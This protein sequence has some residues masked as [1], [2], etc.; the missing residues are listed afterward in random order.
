MTSHDTPADRPRRGDV[1]PSLNGL[2]RSGGKVV[3]VYAEGERSAKSTQVDAA[4]RRARS[5]DYGRLMEHAMVRVQAGGIRNAARRRSTVVSR[6]ADRR[7]AGRRLAEALGDRRFGGP[8]GLRTCPAAGFPWPTRSP[9][10]GAP[11]DVLISQAGAAASAG[12]RDGGDRRREAEVV[13][14]DV[15]GLR[16]V[17]PTGSSR[18]S[19][20]AN[21]PSSTRASPIPA[22]PA[23]AAAPHRP[24]GHRRRRRDRDGRD[25]PRVRAASPTPAARPASSSPCRSAPR[26]RS[27]P[28]PRPMRSSR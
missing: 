8:G 3:T 15:V 21:A 27:P 7:D 5:R 28:F 22:R 9:A 25:G 26:T 14:E 20:V 2:P 10:L 16:L 24:H 17:A 1:D 19:S 13:N 23:P 18:R 12:G 6:F 4:F 11:L